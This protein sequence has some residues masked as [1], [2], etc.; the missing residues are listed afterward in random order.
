MRQPAGSR[1]S[2]DYKVMRRALSSALLVLALAV[3]SSV[4]AAERR[5]HG[6]VT[7]ERTR[8]PVAGAIVE[9]FPIEQVLKA[10]YQEKGPARLS[11]RLHQV[12]P[13]G[14]ATSD[15]HGRFALRTSA[16][17]LCTITA[18]SR[19]G[20]AQQTIAIPTTKMPIELKV[21]WP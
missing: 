6:R 12:P 9:L 21:R 16:E 2:I 10:K 20:A 7:N 11:Q 1:S 3:S 15:K 5:I 8:A 19:E 17:G 4:D 13:A 18:G 14:R